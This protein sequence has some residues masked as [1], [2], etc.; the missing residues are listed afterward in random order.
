MMPKTFFKIHAELLKSQVNDNY[1]LRLV[2]F[3]FIVKDEF[4]QSVE[5]EIN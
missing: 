2:N 5:N 4:L 3:Y 1:F